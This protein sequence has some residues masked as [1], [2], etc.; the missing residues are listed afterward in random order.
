M[1]STLKLLNPRWERE[2]KPP[3]CELF[4]L[5]RDKGSFPDLSARR[6]AGIRESPRSRQGVG[7]AEGGPSFS[8][9]VSCTEVERA[10]QAREYQV[11]EH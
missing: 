8:F 5:W 1:A 4:A 2:R 10:F 6:G 3:L 9:A 11:G 7:S